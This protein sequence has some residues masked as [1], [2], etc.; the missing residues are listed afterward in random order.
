MIKILFIC[1]GSICRSPM[2]MFALRD[3]VRR[4][5]TQIFG[6]VKDLQNQFQI[7][8]AATSR[9]EIGNPVYPPAK[10]KLN[11]E[12]IRC[13]GYAARKMVKEDYDRYDFIIGM[14][15]ENLYDMYAICEGNDPYAGG[16]WRRDVSGKTPERNIERVFDPV[17]RRGQKISLLLDYTDRPGEVADPWYTGNFDATWRDV[18]D[19]CHGF[20]LWLRA[21]GK[22]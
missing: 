22:L 13:D 11:Q 9:E 6:R 19:G 18:Q 7:D 2:S 5:G 20:L 16:W 21:Q 8:C 1:H 3:M 4:E 12:G 17:E 14:D 10:R 15:Q